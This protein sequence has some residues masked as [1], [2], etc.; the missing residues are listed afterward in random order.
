MFSG[1]LPAQSVEAELLGKGL[2]ES[3]HRSCC[4]SCSGKVAFRSGELGFLAG[5]GSRED[6]GKGSHIPDSSLLK[7]KGGDLYGSGGSGGRGGWSLGAL[8]V[9]S[10]TGRGSGALGE[11]SLGWAWRVW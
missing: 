6:R 4:S 10:S 2:E 3:P 5:A 7:V 1:V 11:S 9:V 8:P